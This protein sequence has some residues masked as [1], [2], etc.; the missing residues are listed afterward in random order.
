MVACFLFVVSWH[1]ACGELFW[2]PQGG[3]LKETCTRG[4]RFANCFDCLNGRVFF[5]CCVLARCVWRAFL[6]SPGGTLEQNNA[7]GAW[8]LRIASICELLRFAN[9]FDLRIA[10]IFE[11]LRFANCF[12]LRIASICELLRFAN[13]FDLRIASSCE[14]LRFANCFDCLNGRVFF[15]LLS[16]R[17]LTRD[18]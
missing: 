11:L 5:V 18:T 1:G 6:A 8:D 9:C 10:S 12:D 14:L 15:C 17:T 13:C 7:R 3:P 2:L 4:L 16:A